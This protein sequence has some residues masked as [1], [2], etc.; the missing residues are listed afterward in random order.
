MSVERAGGCGEA[1]EA[2]SFARMARLDSDLCV[3]LRGALLWAD[4]RM[5]RSGEAE[6]MQLNSHDPAVTEVLSPLD[7]AGD[8]VVM[9]C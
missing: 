6:T 2:V 8:A 7:R 1:R 5:M 3:R 4:P 9:P